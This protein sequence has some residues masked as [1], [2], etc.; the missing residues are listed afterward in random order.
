MYCDVSLHLNSL[1]CI[2]PISKLSVLV[3]LYLPEE[4]LLALLNNL[5]RSNLT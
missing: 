5:T 3:L 2:M 1:L 4:S